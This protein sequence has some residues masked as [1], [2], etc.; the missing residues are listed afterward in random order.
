MP[1]VIAGGTGFVG[2]AV[3]HNFANRGDQVYVLTRHPEPDLPNITFIE[4]LT[5]RSQPE[6]ALNH[7]SVDAFINLAGE[8][9]NKGRWTRRK[10]EAI[11]QSRIRATQ[12]SI[13]IVK[14]LNEKPNVYINAS[15]IGYYGNST[16]QTFVET[17]VSL[18]NS[19]P[20]RVCERW[21]AEAKNTEGLGVRTVITRIGV[22]MGKGGG[23][24]P[25]MMLPYHLFA[26]GTIGTG[27]QWVSWIHLD[28]LIGL[29]RFIV[30]NESITGPV[31]LTAP[32][33]VR[34]EQLGKTIAS[35]LSRP[36]WF[37]VPEW[38]I[39]LFFGEMSNI[40]LEGQ[41]VLPIKALEA[42]YVFNFQRIEEALHDLN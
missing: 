10:K 15:A 28:D 40:L 16:D 31:N 22:V 33:P 12:E 32:H 4:W 23:A 17:S 8:P 14:R 30:E 11:L 34:M 27:K 20:S 5:D 21:E 6:K 3:A 19:F 29:I 2:K 36:H 41:K 13:K 24:L 9:L 38:L 39:K 1:I 26:G 42:G 37:P 25:K 18:E 7:L 35:V